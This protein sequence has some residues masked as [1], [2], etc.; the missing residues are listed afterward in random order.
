[1]TKNDI[2]VAD[3]IDGKPLFD[4]Q[5]P[6]RIVAP[7]TLRRAIV[8]MLERLE[9]V[10]LRKVMQ[11]TSPA[12]RVAAR[13]LRDRSARLAAP[14]GYAWELP[15]GFRPALPA[16][17]PMSAAKVDL[18]RHLFY[19]PRLSG[20]STQSCATCHEQARV[21]PTARRTASDRPAIAPARRMSLANIAYASALTWANPTMTR[22]ED[23]ALM[24]M[25]GEHPIELD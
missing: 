1:M 21:L 8:R 23:Q 24:P 3:T 22:L 9:L 4:Y 20:N 18:G 19:D 11:S 25:Y 6:L 5:G 14:D 17:N 2:I 15:A 13:S 10:R 7:R 16:D 12:A